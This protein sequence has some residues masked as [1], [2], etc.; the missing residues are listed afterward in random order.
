MFLFKMWNHFLLFDLLTFEVR[1]Q[2]FSFIRSIDVWSTQST[3]F[4][5]SIYWRLKYAINHFL[6]FDLLTF[7]VR[8]QPFSFIRSIDVWSTQ[9]TIFFYSIY[10]RN[11]QFSFIERLNYAINWKSKDELIIN[12]LLWAPTHGYASSGRPART[13]ISSVGTLDA[14]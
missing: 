7:E 9:S 10:W 1:N 4:F 11:Q 8:N 12:V 3:I 14:I 5:Y 2:P 13:Y 6:L